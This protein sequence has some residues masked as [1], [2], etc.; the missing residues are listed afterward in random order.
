MVF[1]ITYAITVLILYKPACM[2]R[3][4]LH[5]FV[6]ILIIIIPVILHAQSFPDLKF[7]PVHSSTALPAKNVNSIARDGNGLMW[8]ST[9]SG[10]LLRY[11]AN[12]VK[13]VI[14]PH[15]SAASLQD[16][17]IDKN[18]QIYI[19]SADGLL[20]YDPLTDKL[21]RYRHAEN[22]KAS[23]ASDDKPHPFVDSKD[24]VWVSSTNGLQQFDA[25][26]GKFVLYQTPALPA[27]FPKD[28]YNHLESIAEDHKGNIWIAS[29][30]GLYKADTIHKTLLAFYHEKYSWV[31]HIYIDAQDQCW[32]TTWGS[33]IMKFDPVSAKFT[34][35]ELPGM[36]NNITHGICEYED[37][38]HK[39]WI[40][41]SDYESLVLLDPVT[42]KF[43]KYVVDGGVNF[44]YAENHNR[45]WLAT[46]KGLFLMDNV[47][48]QITNYP[49][50][51]QLNISSGNFGHPQ[52]WFDQGNQI[53]LT[54]Y[55]A[56]GIYHFTKDLKYL[57]QQ[58]AIPPT[59]TSLKSSVVSYILEDKNHHTW[60]STD[61]GLIK[62][63]GQRFDVFIPKN[64][65]NSD[66][67]TSFRNIIQRPDGK[68]WVRSSQ[69]GMYIFDPAK[70]QF[71]KKYSPDS[72]EHISSS[73]TD[74]HGR[75]WI[76][77]DNGIYLFDEKREVFISYSLLRPE[78]NSSKLW[79]RI[80][81]MLEDHQNRLWISTFAGVAFFDV[82]KRQFS[83]P[84]ELN[85]SGFNTSYRLLQDDKK[86]T[87]VVANEKLIV[88][89]PDNG[90]TKSFGA[91]I[92]V[93]D[94][95]DD[96]GLFRKTNDGKLWLSY[97]GGLVSYDPES[98]LNIKNIQGNILITDVYEDDA[99]MPY[100]GT[101]LIRVN[102]NA[103][104]IRIRFAYTNY[105]IAKKN[106][107]YYKVHQQNKNATWQKSNGEISFINLAPGTYDLELKGENLSLNNEP[108]VATFKIII[109]PKWYQT[110]WFKIVL[111][112]LAFIIITVLIQLRIRNIKSKA[113]LRQKITESEMAALKAQM[114]PHFM[115]NCINS[116]DSFIYSND[117]YNATLYLNKFAKL[118]RN[119]LD[120]SKENTV[121]LS[122][123]I[124]TLKLYIEL[125]ELRHEGKFTTHFNIDKELE[126][127][128]IIV[129][130]LIIQPFVE[131]AILHGLRNKNSNDGILDISIQKSGDSIEYIITDNGIGRTASALLNLHKPSSHGMSISFD[132][133]RL[134]N[135]EKNP[136]VIIK[137][138]VEDDSQSGTT[139]IV[140]L[141][142]KYRYD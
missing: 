103:S 4:P 131:N 10:S 140:S 138:R 49:L 115:F 133:I 110:L 96:Y 16:I 34:H 116:I 90:H 137:D 95:F 67:G 65:F 36:K 78:A 43:Q 112:A 128:Q 139:V 52:F 107:L 73:L 8:L 89:N 46:S 82:E 51:Q 122:N 69:Y 74:K 7:F 77:T 54:G 86:N 135:Q 23:L 27:R 124:D 70:E 44:V 19:S 35:L 40:C 38:H 50:Y 42:E 15:K 63:S 24:R 48:Q 9:E 100:F 126:N 30:Y 32:L 81:D 101:S 57:S 102:N 59:S 45:I 14:S 93:P 37:I 31:T 11:D 76:G 121:L 26:S 33:G 114:N 5:I 106:V 79:N 113:S 72:L 91:E 88:I 6:L 18:N 3:W 13:E 83:F 142:T 109:P 71:E 17:S 97:P 141:K 92:G 21:N 125:E 80:I 25:V 28:Q 105:S 84:A 41:F 39:H 129:P 120:S 108:V 87:W 98:L 47:Q 68:W 123:D 117:K 99:R 132:R 20:H 60:Y 118:L 136:S 29:A 56:K 2:Y 12:Y 64:G 134:F 94:G 55:F 66:K 22:D 75:L 1:I 58:K 111:A 127:T 53:W 130:P 119:I 62:Q 104:A 61:S 85:A